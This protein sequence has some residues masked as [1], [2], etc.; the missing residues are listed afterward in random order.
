MKTWDDYKKTMIIE[1]EAFDLA[2]AGQTEAL[3]KMISHLGSIDEKN[4]KGHS[5]LMLAAYNGQVETTQVLIDLGADPNSIDN[6]ENSILMG[7]A[8]KGH[9]EIFRILLFAG[10]DP[11]YQ[12]RKGQTALQFAEM[13]SRKQIVEILVGKKESEMQRVQRTFKAW[14]KHLTPKKQGE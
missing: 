14:A 10:A 4:A 1:S 12:N 5:V 11:T 9:S 3:R 7:V 13:F 6:N 2:R 8:F